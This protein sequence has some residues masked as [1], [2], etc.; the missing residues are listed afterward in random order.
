MRMV[1]RLA[2]P[3][4]PRKPKVSPGWTLK[5]IPSTATKLA[6]AFLEV[7]GDDRRGW[8]HDVPR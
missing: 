2:A 5:S 7:A 1:D 4:G 6:E 3:L 8:A